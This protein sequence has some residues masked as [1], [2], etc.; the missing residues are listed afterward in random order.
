MQVLPPRPWPSSFH[1]GHGHYCPPRSRSS[2]VRNRPVCRALVRS[3]ATDAGDRRTHGA[4]AEAK[5]V[6]LMFV[7]K[8]PG[9]A[10]WHRRGALAAVALTRYIQPA[11][12]R[13]TPGC[14]GVLGNV[15][16]M[17]AV[18]LVASYI[19]ARRASRVDPLVALRRNNFQE[20]KKNHD[21]DEE[22]LRC[23]TRPAHARARSRGSYGSHF[24]ASGT[25]TSRCSAPTAPRAMRARSLFQPAQKG[26]VLTRHGGPGRQTVEDRKRGRHRR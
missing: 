2:L 5:T 15:A 16:V 12:R 10:A 20:K 18:A 13:R 24:T 8:G 23:R 21:H 4:G 11:L 3:D 9:G 17:L 19:P 22:T 25:A 1:H 7:C 26:K 14:D 6:R